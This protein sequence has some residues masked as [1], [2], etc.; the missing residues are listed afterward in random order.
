M[1]ILEHLVTKPADHESNCVRVNVTHKEGHR[2]TVSKV[3][4]ISVGAGDSEAV[5]DGIAGVPELNDELFAPDGAPPGG[6][7]YGAEGCWI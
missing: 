6:S 2:P 3:T 1:K 5:V 7:E 4:G